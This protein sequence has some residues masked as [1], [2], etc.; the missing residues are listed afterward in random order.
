MSADVLTSNVAKPPTV[1]VIACKNSHPTFHLN[2][3]C[4]YQARACFLS[5][6]RSKRRL[7][8]ANHRT[9]YWSN[10]SYDW[11]STV[12]AYSNSETEN[13]PGLSQLCKLLQ[14][15]LSLPVFSHPPWDRTVGLL[16]WLLN[17]VHGMKAQWTPAKFGE[18]IL[19]EQEMGPD[20]SSYQYTKFHCADKT[21]IK[22]SYLHNG[23][24]YTGNMASLYWTKPRA[25]LEKHDLSRH[26]DFHSKNKTVVVIP[27]INGFLKI[28]Q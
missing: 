23:I 1:T 27:F 18:M 26:A 17:M 28:K 15:G 20:S 22:W 14:G 24:F 4:L 8:S 13:R 6:A 11:P 21:V 3:R 19:Q 12:W 9:G 2:L 10:L 5:L 25:Q 16:Q 7:C